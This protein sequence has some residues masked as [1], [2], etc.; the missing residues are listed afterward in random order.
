MVTTVNKTCAGMTL[1]VVFA[2]PGVW[3]DWVDARC[4]I[5]P[6]GEDHVSEVVPCVFSQRQGH[7]NI[8]RADGVFY[9]L[10]PRGDGPGNFTDKNGED[11]YRQSGMREDGQIFRFLNET[12]YVYWDTSGLPGTGDAD[13]YTA[14]YTTVKFDATARIPCSLTIHGKTDTGDCAIGINRGPKQGQAAIAIMRADGVERVLQFDGGEVVSP[15][16]GKVRAQFKSDDWEIAIDDEE[17][18]RIPRAAIVG[19]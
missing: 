18:Y 13:Q 3:A 11:V 7:I 12:V 5:Y 8:D 19:G 10:S 15:G 17:V 14:P 1:A 4:D 16:K 6:R 2:T 9:S